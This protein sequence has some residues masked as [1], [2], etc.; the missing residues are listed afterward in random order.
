MNTDVTTALMVA[1]YL[2]MI[3]QKFEG[4]LNGFFLKIYYFGFATYF[5]R[6]KKKVQNDEDWFMDDDDDDDDM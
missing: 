5:T 2:S 3:V 4:K 1:H 6:C